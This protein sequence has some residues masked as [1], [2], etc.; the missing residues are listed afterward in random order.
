MRG[1]NRCDC[2]GRFFSPEDG[3][4]IDEDLSLDLYGNLRQKWWAYCGPCT[5]PE[6]THQ[7]QE[8]SA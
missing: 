1:W 8:V 4:R 6:H 5:K 3:F 2:C 7:R